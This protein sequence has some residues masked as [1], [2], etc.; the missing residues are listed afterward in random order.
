MTDQDYYNFRFSG[1]QRLYGLCGAESIRKGHV[2]VVGL[3]GVGSWVVESLARTGIES[4][5]LVDYD[6]ICVSNTNRQLHA[7]ESNIGRMKTQALKDRVLS[8]NKNCNV[9]LIEEIYSK[10]NESLVFKDDY[11]VVVDC[12]DKS[13]DKENLIVACRERNTPVVVVGSAGGRQDLSKVKVSDLSQTEVDPL[14]HIM[15][16][17]LRKNHGFPRLPK[18]MDIPTVYSIETPMF[19]SEDGGVTTER[20]DKFLKPLD[21]QTGFGTAT[22]ITGTFAFHATQQ[23]IRY[24]VTFADK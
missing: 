8:I 23:S 5:T 13:I 18:K 3:G 2:L 12:I 11:D 17:S 16:K 6:D 22:H 21:C 14:L 20:P 15:R 4:L 7:T 24:L 9:N 1:I 19:P 10:D